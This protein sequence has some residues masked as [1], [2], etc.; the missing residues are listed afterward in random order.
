MFTDP[1]QLE[2]ECLAK[3]CGDGELA[4]FFKQKSVLEINVGT[5]DERGM[6]YRGME[7]GQRQADQVRGLCT[8]LGE[9]WQ[10]P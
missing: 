9:G 2:T 5:S 10:D 8:G 4:E 1:N 7:R 6:Q 3:K